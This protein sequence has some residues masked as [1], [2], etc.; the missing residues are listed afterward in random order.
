M[1]RFLSIVILGIFFMNI[2]ISGYVKVPKNERKQYRLEPAPSVTVQNNVSFK[3]TLPNT[4][5]SGTYAL[6]DSSGNGYGMV[7][8]NTRPLFVDIDNSNWF[9]CYR[10][11]AGEQTTHGQIGGAFSTDG[12]D[13]QTYSNLNYNGNPPWGGGTGA[14]QGG[15]QTAQGR[16]PSAL[17]TPDQPL[18][19]WNEYAANAA[20]SNGSLYDGRPYYAYDEFGWDGGSF[21]YPAD[22]DLLWSTA[23][24]DLWV[25]SV[26]V[27]YDN[28]MGMNVVNAVYNDWTRGDRWLFHSEAYEDGFVVFGEEQKVIDEVVDLV[29]GDDTG[30][31]NTSPYVSF[32][33]GGLGMVGVIGLFL[34]ADTDE[35]A[36]SNYHTGIFKM[37]DDHGASWYGGPTGDPSL[38]HATGASGDQYYF[39]PDAAWDDLVATQFS[40]EIEDECAGT[41]HMLDSFWSYYEDDMKVDS[42]GN[43][44]FVIQVLP[45]ESIEEG[46]CWYVPEAGLYHFT[47]DRQYINNPGPVNTDTG[48][49]WSFVMTGQGTW[50]FNDLTGDTYIWNNTS[51]LAFSK[52]NADVVYVTTNM[53]TPGEFVEIDYDPCGDIS[54]I[55]D[56]WEEYPYWSE[57]VYVVKSEDGGRNWWNPLNTTN[58]PDDTG[59][60]CPSGLPKCAPDETYPHAAQ[61]GTN[62]EMYLIYNQPNWAF[63]EIGDLLGADFMN[64]VF[65]GT[66]VVDDSNIEEYSFDGASSCY[67][68]PGDVT[69][70][71]VL[72]VLDIVGLVNHILGL[73]PLADS[74]SADYS[75]DAVIYV[76]DIV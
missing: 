74:F 14:G 75:G 59:G 65:V 11:Y 66:A 7:A 45:C 58:T 47:I 12:Q 21:S 44:H 1:K 31:Y 61:W 56:Q 53:G 37:S 73:S 50:G 5:N 42:E 22:L 32:T 43:P 30:S 41:T 34:G 39:I 63:N 9:A 26:A 55:P 25:G 36:I 17:G 29:G 62:D 38:G 20:N 48:W 33:P 71:G 10:Q 3:A 18:A 49:R 15:L 69:G 57:D 60:I 23:P 35:S 2:A 67:G 27:S 40:Y 72:N 54:Q 8:A 52:D 6:V 28:D 46:F 19:I 24:K 64:W 13:W 51:S 16:Y 70:D 4:R 76:L 68:D